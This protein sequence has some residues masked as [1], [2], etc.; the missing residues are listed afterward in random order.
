MIIRT[1]A[2]VLRAMDYGET[3]RIVTLFTREKGKLAV[4]AKGARLPKSRFG[5]TL[6][7]MAYTQV[8]FYHKPT[9]SLQTLTESAHV[10]PLM[11]ISRDL[12]KLAVGQRLVELVA[13]L[14]PAEEPHPPV[15]NLLVEVLETLNAATDR[16]EN[17]LA[18][19]QL[20]LAII[21][22][23]AP[24]IDKQT[25]EA[26][27]NEGGLLNLDTG[28]ISPLHTASTATRQASRLALRAYAIFA[29]ADLDTVMRMHLDPPL[30]TEVNRLV[31]QYLQFHLEDAYPT[32]S[33]KI[34]GRLLG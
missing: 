20:R 29:R 22:G 23:F 16:T 31:D 27:S 14:I 7:P 2:V 5:A 10:R 17:L 24:H 1:D 3:S 25:V 15:F 9:R 11:G 4:L 6:Q 30:R 19:F 32:R 28:A 8:V 33:E 18:Y 26:L 13:A 12:V 21:L 34:T